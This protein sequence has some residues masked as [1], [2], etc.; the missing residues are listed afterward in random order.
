MSDVVSQKHDIKGL[1]VQSKY[2]NKYEL[3]WDWIHVQKLYS[4]IQYVFICWL[5]FK[6][7]VGLS[8]TINPYWKASRALQIFFIIRI[9]ETG[10]MFKTFTFTF[11][12]YLVVE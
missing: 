10:F 6:D 2:F 5:T 8:F 7:N 4:S 12:I 3:L 11:D 9:A 1:V